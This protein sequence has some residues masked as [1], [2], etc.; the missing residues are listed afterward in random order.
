MAEALIEA[1][2]SNVLRIFEKMTD[3]R[4]LAGDLK[5]K[6]KQLATKNASAGITDANQTLTDL[7]EKGFITLSG[8]AKE[9]PHPRPNASYR[10]TDKGREFLRPARPDLADEQLQTQE[11]F[12]LLQVFRAKEQKLTRSELNGRLKTRAAM[13][14]L[15][16]DVKAAPVTVDYHLAMLVDKGALVEEKRGNSV[17]YSLNREA[18]ARTLASVKQHDGVSFTM[19]GETLNALIAAARQASPLPAALL[20]SRA[21]EPVSPT[22]SRPLGPDAIADYV[23]LLQSDLYAGKDLIPIHEVRR[24]VAE[25][26]GAAAAGHPTFD[27]LIKQMRSE[28]QLRLIAISDNRDA[29]QQQLDDSIPG[30]N[31]TIF[32]IVIR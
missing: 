10:L 24:V 16:F 9:G 26:H 7:I 14:Q 13:G 1:H 28:G 30:M 8:S 17:S 22:N 25:H 32:Y 21:A 18:G 29:T 23:A 12:I 31:E 2:P 19:T 6:L 3:G 11:A 15:E 20:E 27:P 5:R 4:L